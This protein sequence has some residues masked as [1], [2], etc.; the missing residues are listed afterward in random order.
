MPNADLPLLFG[1][2]P[3]CPNTASFS[4]ASSSGFAE[5]QCCLSGLNPGFL[6]EYSLMRTTQQTLTITFY[7]RVMQQ[8]SKTVLSI[9]GFR[10]RAASP[11]KRAK[12]INNKVKSL[13]SQSVWNARFTDFSS[14]RECGCVSY[15]C[16]F[17]CV[18]SS[19]S[20]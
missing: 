14:V 8:I 1:T 15:L 13:Y 19:A 10:P 6:C 4:A 18:L 20:S 2:P 11:H 16:E 9:E 12:S 3:P 7:T 5:N 17:F